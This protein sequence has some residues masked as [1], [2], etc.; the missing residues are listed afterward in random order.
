M[1]LI[2]VVGLTSQQASW[3]LDW[4]DQLID[5]LKSLTFLLAK[6]KLNYFIVFLKWTHSLMWRPYN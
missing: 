2:V 6:W 3:L 4:G 5:I 1:Q